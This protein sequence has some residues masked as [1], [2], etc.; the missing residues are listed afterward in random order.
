MQYHF[1]L[2]SW[3]LRVKPKLRVELNYLLVLGTLWN[4][5]LRYVALCINK[6]LRILAMRGESSV[7]LRNK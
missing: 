2:L 5:P 3:S 7:Q 4:F 1:F 6:P